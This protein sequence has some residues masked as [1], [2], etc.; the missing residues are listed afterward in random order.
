MASIPEPSTEGGQ[1]GR[2][3]RPVPKWSGPD[4]IIVLLLFYM[5]PFSSV[6]KCITVFMQ[7]PL[8]LQLKSLLVCS[9]FDSAL[10]DF[11]AA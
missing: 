1:A 4:E 11:T 7:I 6:V 5:E 9:D 3:G 8:I 10:K 2:Q